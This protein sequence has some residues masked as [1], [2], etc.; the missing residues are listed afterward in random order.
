MS[1]LLLAPRQS[2]GTSLGRLA[3]V[4]AT[5]ESGGDIR[6]QDQS[7]SFSACFLEGASPFS[8]AP[9]EIFEAVVHLFERE[10][11]CALKLFG[12]GPSGT[13]GYFADNGV[14][15][16][17]VAAWIAIIMELVGGIRSAGGRR[18]VK[19]RKE[20]DAGNLPV[21]MAL[22]GRSYGPMSPARQ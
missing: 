7:N 1:K 19:R 3:E 11:E 6:S 20:V 9:L 22:R 5:R 10:P 18:N 14:P 15:L 17:E 12:F 2:R 16:P 21:R 4:T 13:E 8:H